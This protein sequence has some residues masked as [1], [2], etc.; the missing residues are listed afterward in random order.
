MKPPEILSDHP[1]DGKRLAQLK[2]W[3]ARAQAAKSA[4]SAGRIAP[5]AK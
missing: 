5:E 4:W 3:V 1:S 2:Q